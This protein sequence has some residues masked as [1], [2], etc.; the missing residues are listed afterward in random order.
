VAKKSDK[1]SSIARSIA[2]AVSTASPIL[3]IGGPITARGRSTLP[4]AQ[5]T[6]GTPV[7]WSF[8]GTAL[9]CWFRFFLRY[10]EGL[11]PR[12]IANYFALGS[13][14][15]GLHEGKTDG[16][17]ASGGAELQVELPEAK[18]LHAARM[19]GPPMPEAV[20]VEQTIYIEDGPLKDLFSSR[21]DRLEQSPRGGK[22]T[23]D[24]K[25]AGAERQTDGDYWNVNG[26]ILG[27]ILATG[28]V[29]AIVDVI[30]KTK[31]PKIRQYEVRMTDAKRAAFETLILDIVEQIRVKMRRWKAGEDA[32]TSFPK[33]IKACVVLGQRCPYYEHCWGSGATTHL[34]QRRERT[35][36]QK[37]LL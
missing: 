5:R 4:R 35:E 28:A 1:R 20:A 31:V 26:E 23:R 13:A 15:H 29:K 19:K 6:E 17:I 9:D 12:R 36:W 34:Y 8:F 7:G 3:L 21:P 16:Q 11:E 10:V 25:T 14:Y 30:T 22:Q 37:R 33:N 24:F 32:A 2:P 27:Q 18:R